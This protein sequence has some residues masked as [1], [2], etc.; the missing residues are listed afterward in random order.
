MPK[1]EDRGASVSTEHLPTGAWDSGLDDPIDL[2]PLI[3]VLFT[4]YVGV[5]EKVSVTYTEMLLAGGALETLQVIHFV[6]HAHRHLIGTDPLVTGSTEAI[7]SKKPEIVSPAQLPSQLV[8]E[9]PPHL[10]QPT[11]TEVTAEAILV[12]VLVDGFQEVAVPYVLLAATT[13]QQGWGD[14][15][16]LI[17][18]FLGRVQALPFDGRGHWGAGRRA[19]RRGRS[20]CGARLAGCLDS[21]PLGRSGA[22]APA[23]PLARSLRRRACPSALK[24]SHS[25]PCLSTGHCTS[26]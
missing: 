25:A 11:P 18:G 10:S 15:Q 21:D 14:L 3:D 26:R 8:V 17:Y 2:G 22:A 9:A 1:H 12:P 19:G 20:L 23:P 13:C 5:D 6:F 24:D 16:H 7:L 4:H